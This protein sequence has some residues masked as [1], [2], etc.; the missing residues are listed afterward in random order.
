MP[1][2]LVHA[3][4]LHR[5]RVIA[6]YTLIEALR[7]R[8]LWLVG[9]VVVAGLC[10]TAFLGQVAI[11]ESTQIQ[12]AF[13]AALLRICAVFI[14]TSFIVTSMV[15]EA[16]DKGMELLLALPLP[17]SSYFFGKLAGFALLAASVALLVSLPLVPFAS[18]QSVAAWS[19]SLV[20][21]LAIMTALSLFCVISLNHVTGALGAVAGFYVLSRS[22]SAIQIIAASPLDANG[23]A[24]QRVTNW[25]ID[26]IALLLP[27]MDSMTSTEW[28]LYAPPAAGVLGQILLQSM[29]YVALLCGAA[30]FDLYRKNY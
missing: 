7:N 27:R 17:R 13:L 10:I 30:L 22:V 16:N 21:E 12:A 8:L 28:L 5:V 1:D 9:M 4:P 29:I 19:A 3:S 2:P 25:A 26:L 18:W 24:L 6:R 14:V 23:S 11:T 20:C 15:R